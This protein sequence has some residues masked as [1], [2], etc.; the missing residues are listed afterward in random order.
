MRRFLSLL[1]WVAASSAVA[2]NAAYTP[3][4]PSMADKT[5]ATDIDSA[6]VAARGNSRVREGSKVRATL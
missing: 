6:A 1:V 4:T 3:I 2:G 5:V